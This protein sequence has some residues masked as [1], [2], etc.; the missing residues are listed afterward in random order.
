MSRGN[1]EWILDRIRRQAPKVRKTGCVCAVC[2][3]PMPVGTPI[4][5]VRQETNDRGRPT[6]RQGCIRPAHPDCVDLVLT[7]QLQPPW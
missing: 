5:F 4:R 7:G 1:L 3:G 2:G 6:K